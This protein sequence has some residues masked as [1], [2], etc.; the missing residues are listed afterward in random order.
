ME[1]TSQTLANAETELMDDPGNT[2][3]RASA[4]VSA[5]KLPTT[6]TSAFMVII[7]TLSNRLINRLITLHSPLLLVLKTQEKL[8]R[9]LAR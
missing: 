7:N 5:S 4:K 8:W 3:D 1:G 2:R 9:L 6:Q